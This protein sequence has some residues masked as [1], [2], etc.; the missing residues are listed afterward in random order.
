MSM[1]FLFKIRSLKRRR[2]EVRELSSSDF[3]DSTMFVRLDRLYQ[4]IKN[5]S[6]LYDLTRGCWR[7]PV[8]RARQVRYVCGAYEGII[9]SVYEPERWFRVT[10][11][12]MPVFFK[13]VD[14][15]ARLGLVPLYTDGSRIAFS[16]SPAPPELWNALKGNRVTFLGKGA[17]YY[18]EK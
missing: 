7:T 3:P 11:A 8:Y 17:V 4:F 15:K 13:M 9:M 5:R 1:G 10:E 12:N 16:G 14:K 18:L 2:S 6:E